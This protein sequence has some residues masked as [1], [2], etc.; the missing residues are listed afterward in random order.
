MASP[1][2]RSYI[3]LTVN[4][5][6]PID[7]YDA[8]IEYARTSLPDWTPVTGSIEDT[9][10]QA[11]SEMTGRLLG[12]INR[13]PSGNIEG[14]LRL[15]QIERN[16]GTS[17]S[18]SVEIQFVN[19]DGAT[20][21]TGTRFGYSQ[22][23]GDTTSLYIFETT[24]D[25]LVAPGS[26]SVNAA[27]RGVTLA[28]YPAIPA[29]TSL[30]LLSAVSSIDSVQLL[31]DLVVGADAES[32]AEFLNRGINKFASLSEALTTP[33]QFTAH[34]TDTYTNSY[35]VTTTSRLKT[36]LA[37]RALS[38]SG[39]SVTANI[40]AGASA[41]A[42]GD[43]IHLVDA[44]DSTFDGVFTLTSVTSPNVVWAQ[45]GTN[46]SA[47]FGANTVLT[48]HKLQ[49][50]AQN[51]YV[52]VYVSDVGGASL[53]HSSLTAIEDDLTNRAVAGLVVRVD[54]AKVIPVSVAVNVVIKSNNVTGSTVETAIQ[55]ALDNY[56]HPDH[57]TWGDAIYMNEIIA[58][59]DGVAGVERVVSITLTENSDYMTKT[60]NDLFFTYKGLLPLNSTTMTVS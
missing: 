17:P 50:A 9:I 27:L 32:T 41:M 53:S 10:V 35:R 6:Q 12:A 57:W 28:R 38:R 39:A 40:G 54:N 22:Y 26:S 45:T 47:G 34:L 44:A 20:V 15:F 1:D 56:L 42:T 36:Q 58:L 60:G 24:D 21:P 48:S 30:Q 43:V 23:N 13:L 16:S 37:V 25:V 51:G 5:L 4:D 52:S 11:A 31:S 19:D 59:I 55:S 3:D 49:S 33:S 29:G 2:A 7:I 14:L 46:A 8:A 18:A